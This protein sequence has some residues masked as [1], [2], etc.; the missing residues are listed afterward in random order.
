M[1]ESARDGKGGYGGGKL[2]GTGVLLVRH[3]GGLVEGNSL[4]DEFEVSLQGSLR[5]LALCALEKK[6]WGCSC[7]W[8]Q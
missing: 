1:L 4:D 2:T 8:R 5:W 7:G 3:V 6:L